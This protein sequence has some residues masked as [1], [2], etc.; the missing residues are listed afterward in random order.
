[1]KTRNLKSFL[2]VAVVTA[3]AAGL[4]TGCAEE[5]RVQP[6]TGKDGQPALPAGTPQTQ[7]VNQAFWSYFQGTYKSQLVVGNDS[8]PVSIS[9]GTT[10]FNGKT[11]GQIVITPLASTGAVRNFTQPVS[12]RLAPVQG[13]QAS[14]TTIYY[15]VVS[16]IFFYA[17]FSVT[18][19]AILFYARVD[20]Q[21]GKGVF[22]PESS[23][24]WFL[25]CSSSA[26]CGSYSTSIGF[27]GLSR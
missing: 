24:L 15:T 10:D 25:D 13:T 21:N 19:L 20:N 18:D 27:W 7:Q 4:F 26:Q 6:R 2:A 9:F 16:E 3:L 22:I 1:M 8:Q 23:G 11:F 5:T 14:Q 12:L 17:P